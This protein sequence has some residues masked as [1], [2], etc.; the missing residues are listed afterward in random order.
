[1]DLLGRLTRTVRS[2][3]GDDRLKRHRTT[4]APFLE[5]MPS[6]PM[7][8][9]GYQF[10]ASNMWLFDP[11]DQAW[12]TAILGAPAEARSA[13]AVVLVERLARERRRDAVDRY[14]L[15]TLLAAMRA[16]L[17]PFDETDLR[18]LLT[19]ARRGD[20]GADEFLRLIPLPVA[21]LER[22][23]RAT[24]LSGS[25]D[26]AVR[27]LLEDLDRPDAGP[28]SEIAGFRGRLRRALDSRELDLS[29]FHTGD[30]WGTAM[31]AWVK[32]H[33]DIP[34][35][36][37]TLLHLSSADSVAPSARWRTRAAE[38]V[39]EPGIEALIR[40]MV[41]ASFSAEL[42][43]RRLIDAPP[44]VS[45]NAS[46]VRGAY[47]AAAVGGWPWVTDT[48]GRA[49]LHWALSGRSDNYARDQAL[50]NTCAAL[51]GGIGTPEAHAALGRMKAKVR[52]RNVGKSVE[53]ALATA[54]ERAGTSPSELLELSVPRLGLDESGR[55]EIPIGEG[56]AV[57]ELDEDGEAS[58][59]WRAPDGR[60]TVTPAKA[61]DGAGVAAAKV[62]L[63][64]LR[65]ALS[66]ERGR[67]E[68]LLVETRSWPC[69]VW[70]ERYVV[71]PLTRPFGRR[72][73][74]R[75]HDAGVTTAG[76]AI[77]TEIVGV[78][79]EPLRLGDDTT[80]SV[81]HPID[82]SVD[83]VRAWRSFLLDRRIR[84]PFK[85][86]F[87]EIY[88]L[89]PAER[90][91]A[92]Y[93]NRFAAHILDYGVAR[94]LMTGRRWGSNFLGPYDGGF[95]SVARRE[96]PT[97]GLRA[98][99]THFAVEEGG[100]VPHAAVLRCS[101]DRVEFRRSAG[102]GGRSRGSDAAEP[103]PLG[104][105]PQVVFSEAMRD[106]DL[107]VGVSSIAADANW[108]DGGA[109]RDFTAYWQATAF[110]DLTASAETRRDVLAWI[111]PQL[112]IA[113]RLALEDRWLRVRGDLRSYRI[114]L[115]SGNILMDPN[116]QYLCIVPGRSA[117]APKRVF[118][119][120]DPDVRLSL[121]LSKAFLLARDTAIAD[122][123]I[124]AQ[125]ERR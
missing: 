71:H 114:H 111:I 69:P 72:L 66:V 49:G 57:L 82:A 34:S 47:W 22:H 55:R 8:G 67:I 10:D 37:A 3:P 54:A 73:I 68:D 32:A 41:D 124:R 74:W 121:I 36:Q 1:M 24:P 46:L 84:Q 103:L 93:S 19:F 108:Q 90:G 102:S 25:L 53:R 16:D 116:D 11:K 2:S 12:F 14:A 113:D 97:Y 85:Q 5:A 88:V 28:A 60:V 23:A 70:R 59:S 105:V 78:D 56:A 91:T 20:R 80:V 7:P 109:N 63:K 42:A 96:F 94:A 6:L 30:S 15:P 39:A 107:F 104:E 86:A 21:A 61:L 115:G 98:E 52:N 62:E 64:E 110:G 120:F 99:F 123:S 87:R 119:P 45:A 101:T 26:R 81:W 95:E 112:A 77:G 50:A 17:P 51:L 118:L 76:T 125:I 75:F 4:A 83:E 89:T 29:T 18:L 44:F 117:D 58:L 43:D 40:Q 13:I 38:L 100:G 65:K 27:G 48:L 9:P 122:P 31:R 35:I 92:T 79:G 106:I 33:A